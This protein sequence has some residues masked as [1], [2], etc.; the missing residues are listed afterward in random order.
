MR[1]RKIKVSLIALAV[2]GAALFSACGAEK[3]SDTETIIEEAA[4][5]ENPAT[6][7]EEASGEAPAISAETGYVDPV[8]KMTVAETAE[9][10]HTHDGLTYGFC[11]PSCLE[12]FSSEPTAYLQ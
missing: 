3:A 2:T 7:A 8:C 10:R 9:Y 4:A 1:G 6:P 5:T 12:R 11:S